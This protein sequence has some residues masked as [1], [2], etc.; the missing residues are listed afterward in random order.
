MKKSLLLLLLP[1]AFALAAP[2][3]SIET[4]AL[5]LDGV[6]RLTMARN[7]ALLAAR[8]AAGAMEAR[9]PQARAWDDPRVGVDIERSGTTRL[10]DWADAEWM[11]SQAIPINAKN[12]VRARAAT[13]EAHAAETSVQQLEIELTV[14][15]RAALARLANV[16]RQIAINREIETLLSQLLEVSRSRYAAGNGMQS[17]ALMAE[18]D[19]VRL[20]E[21]RQDLER[22]A[23]DEQTVLNL[24]MNFPP[25]A[26]L[27]APERNTYVE[28]S[29]SLD[30]LQAAARAARPDLRGA[31]LRRDAAV[32][33]VDLA[34]RQ[35]IPDPE[36]RVEARQFH[37][38]GGLIQ[39]YDTGIFF[40]VPWLNRGKYRGAVAEA[41]QNQ[42]ASER[43]LEAADLQIAGAVRDALRRV[44]T[45]Q[46]NFILFRDRLVPLARQTADAAR[47]AYVNGQGRFLDV[48]TA[49]RT[50]N[51]VAA[52]HE[53]HL[54]DYLV[55]I[56][57]LEGVVGRP[58]ATIT[59]NSRKNG[60]L[61]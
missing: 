3:A 36:L 60:S 15:A 26:P 61:P 59:A 22:R 35:W 21:A 14:R 7:P 33:R 46:L 54:T 19:V 47:I 37:G 40:S 45:F 12:R 1:T 52:A 5:T 38:A 48:M 2:A 30:A 39:E 6:L 57:E 44:E 8:A 10:T 4:N 17:D 28:S 20:L 23:T 24:L 34:R 9:V 29:L 32:A 43:E 27:G 50:L 51:E 16:Q 42:E 31:D 25:Q 41:R 53:N 11:V 55:A 58:L 49:L 18:G 13:A 56:T